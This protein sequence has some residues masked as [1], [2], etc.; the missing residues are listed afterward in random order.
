[1]AIGDQAIRSVVIFK[2]TSTVVVRDQAWR[3]MVIF[4]VSTWESLVKD[5]GYRLLGGA[6]I[7][8]LLKNQPMPQHQI[9]SVEHWLYFI[10]HNSRYRRPDSD[11]YGSITYN[12][13]LLLVVTMPNRFCFLYVFRHSI[14]T[15]TR[16]N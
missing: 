10:A 14:L 9:R 4:K 1:M 2:E 5:R 6:N 7:G 8:V 13:Q 12:R 11:N 3:S 15:Q 16:R